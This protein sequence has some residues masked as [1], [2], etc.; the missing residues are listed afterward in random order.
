MGCNVKSEDFMDEIPGMQII[1]IE[2][3]MILIYIPIAIIGSLK[4]KKENKK[5]T[6]QKRNRRDVSEDVL[7]KNKEYIKRLLEKRKMA[8][9]QRILSEDEDEGGRIADNMDDHTSQ[10]NM[11][12]SKEMFK[13]I[14]SSATNVME[15]A[16]DNPEIERDVKMKSCED[17]VG[18]F[19]RKEERQVENREIGTLSTNEGRITEKTST[20]NDEALDTHPNT[21]KGKGKKAPSKKR[22]RPAQKCASR[23]KAV[24]Q[25]P[26]VEEN[27]SNSMGTL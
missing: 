6:Q 5:P 1:V 15:G 27:N 17:R 19:Q 3:L 12:V 21:K 7:D 10:I 16:A 13:D 2:L 8:K 20:N 14:Q 26:R 9:R 4:K 23:G 24:S 22:G 18:E 25:T 11:E